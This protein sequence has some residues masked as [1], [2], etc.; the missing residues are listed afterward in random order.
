[1]SSQNLD[2]PGVETRFVPWEAKTQAREIA[3]FDIGVM[4]LPDNMHTRGKCGFK[5]LQYMAAGVTPA[6]SDVGVNS[7]IVEHGRGGLVV[8]SLDGF[9]E[10]LESLTLNP[11]LQK[12]MGA[13]SRN[14]VDNEY[15]LHVIGRR[16]AE[17]LHEY[18][19]RVK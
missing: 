10:A 6:V 9:Y 2:I 3:G 18:L 7:Q 8:S 17:I 12:N 11:G 13:Y 19:A 1:M 16:Y 15:S 14:K 5:A 4:P